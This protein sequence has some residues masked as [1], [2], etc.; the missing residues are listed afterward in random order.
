MCLPKLK[1]DQQVTNGELSESFERIS[2]ALQIVCPKAAAIL[3]SEVR[4]LRYGV[5]QTPHI[6]PPVPREWKVYVSDGGHVITQARAGTDYPTVTVR[7][8]V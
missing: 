8:V 3:L 7:E 1:T 6:S 2:D 4:R 5:L